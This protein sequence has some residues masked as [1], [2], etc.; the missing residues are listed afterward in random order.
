MSRVVIFAAI[1]IV[2]TFASSIKSK[3]LVEQNDYHFLGESHG[4]WAGWFHDK[5]I[6]EYDS[7]SHPDDILEKCLETCAITHGK[8]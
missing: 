6:N 5:P 4:N 3:L 7:R 2:S 1:G 8:Y